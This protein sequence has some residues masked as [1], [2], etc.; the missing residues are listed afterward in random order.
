MSEATIRSSFN[1][2]IYWNL[3]DS[4]GTQALLISHHILLR[5]FVGPD[6]HGLFS[7]YVSLFYLAIFLTNSSFDI[8]L[9][10]F[11][12]YYSHC[13]NRFRFLLTRH[14]IPQF[15]L[16]LCVAAL[17]IA[18]PHFK[19][20]DFFKPYT[21]KISTLPVWLSV[22]IIATFIAE[23]VKK[24]VKYF[25][26]LAFY[27]SV[28]ATVEFLGMLLYLVLFWSCYLLGY[29]ITLE[30]A[31]ACLLIVAALQLIVL[32]IALAKY[33]MQLSDNHEQS[34]AYWWRIEKN[35][36]FIF[37]NQLSGQ[38]FSGN[39]LVPVCAYAIGLEAASFVK[40]VTS[41]SQWLILISQKA[42]GVS[43]M[44][45][46]AQT[47][48]TKNTDRHHWF[49][50]SNTIAHSVIIMAATF[51][52][53]NGQQLVNMY[54]PQSDASFSWPILYFVILMCFIENFFVVYEKWFIIEEK[55]YILMITNLMS[56]GTIYAC[57]QVIMTCY[58]AVSFIVLLF[59]LLALRLST[60]IFLS[61]ITYYVWNIKPTYAVH[62]KSIILGLI[63]SLAWKYTTI[64]YL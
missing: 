28:T 44:A 48:E 7:I 61:I 51:I 25:L 64:N 31:F 50:Y 8:A 32:F 2:S 40:I 19:L 59:I 3:L 27:N 60:F 38:F 20:G 41:V 5:S 15:I 57:A 53:I 45:L 29:K 21:E 33:Y 22:I 14:A 43:T 26:Q 18:L 42:L 37:G 62:T 56:L 49:R 35:R 54:R 1:Y 12:H 58:S 13:K 52:L 23:T 30:L 63:L 46:L 11:Y 10:P 6:F 34:V 36:F 9:A 24:P 55:T 39:V 17:F 47:K 4:I 16:I